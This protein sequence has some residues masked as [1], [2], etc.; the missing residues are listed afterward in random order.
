MFV[1][2]SVRLFHLP[3]QSLSV[4]CRFW[5]HQQ[6]STYSILLVRSEYSLT[7]YNRNNIILFYSQR[8]GSWDRKLHAT[9]STVINNILHILQKIHQNHR[10]TYMIWT[11]PVFPQKA[12]HYAIQRIHRA[13]FSTH[14]LAAAHVQNTC[15]FTRIPM[16]RRHSVTRHTHLVAS[17]VIRKQPVWQF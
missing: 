1:Q 6:P 11:W 7:H 4:C 8:R 10:L 2:S 3:K 5:Y 16:L 15:R 9:S 13:T 14:C 17:F 12:R